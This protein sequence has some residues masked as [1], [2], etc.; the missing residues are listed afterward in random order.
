MAMTPVMGLSRCCGGDMST[1]Q[2]CPPTRHYLQTT[3]DNRRSVRPPSRWGLS[4][5]ARRLGAF[6]ARQAVTSGRRQASRDERR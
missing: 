2:K 4:D 3:S 1:P 5:G 6:C